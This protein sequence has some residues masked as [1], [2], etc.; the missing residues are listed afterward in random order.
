MLL[1]DSAPLGLAILNEVDGISRAVDSIGL[2]ASGAHIREHLPMT[3]ST[4]KGIVGPRSRSE[5]NFVNFVK[6]SK[7]R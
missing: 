7:E 2:S 1:D 6:R 5:V 4:A 3:N